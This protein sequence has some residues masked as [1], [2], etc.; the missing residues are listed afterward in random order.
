MDLWLHTETRN[1]RDD[2]LENVRRNRL[3]RLAKSGRST[4]VRIRIADVAQAV[5]DALAALARS[6]RNGE[7][8]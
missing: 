4:K 5:S 7:T 6:L 1:R 8:A 3:A 2:A